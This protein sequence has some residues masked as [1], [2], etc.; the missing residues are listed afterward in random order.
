MSKSKAKI[1]L[2][3]AT[4]VWLACLPILALLQIFNHNLVWETLLVGIGFAC[5]I[6]YL[7]ARELAQHLHL[8]REMRFGWA[9]VGDILEERFTLSNTGLIPAVWVEISDQSTLANHQ[10]GQV[11][12]IFA[13][14]VP[15]TEAATLIK[16]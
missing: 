5:L 14:N 3:P 11:T 10:I 4:I 9:H 6:A 2:R 16:R 7:W 12:A 13:T 1:R 15:A 8:K